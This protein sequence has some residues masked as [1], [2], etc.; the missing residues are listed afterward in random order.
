M[1]PA[2]FI[3]ARRAAERPAAGPPPAVRAAFTLWVTAVAA[4]AFETALMVGRDPAEGFGAG[5]AVRLVVFTAAV[6]VAVH[7][8]RG[9]GWARITLAIGLGVLGTAS[10]VVEPLGYLLDGGSLADALARAD[11]LEWVFAVSR[12]VHLA[13]V[14]TAVVLMFRPAANRYFREAA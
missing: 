14:L 2:T 7:M 5:L 3:P 12:T 10:L 6:L 13:A 11:A 8:R 4:G 1:M 9:A